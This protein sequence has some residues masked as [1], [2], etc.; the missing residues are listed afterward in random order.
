MARRREFFGYRRKL[1]VERRRLKAAR[2]FVAGFEPAGA[3]QKQVKRLLVAVV[4]LLASKVRAG[5]TVGAYWD[6][7]HLFRDLAEH[8]E[9]RSRGGLRVMA[10]SLSSGD[11]GSVK[12]HR[13]PQRLTTETERRG[14]CE[15]GP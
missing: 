11:L 2:A 8:G 15:E 5:H 7:F 12:I 4:D 14:R 13:P 10:A 1:Y 9:P 3:E 6:F